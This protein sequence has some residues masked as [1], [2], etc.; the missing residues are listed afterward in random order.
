MTQGLN[1]SENGAAIEYSRK[2][3]PLRVHKTPIPLSRNFVSYDPAIQPFIDYTTSRQFTALEDARNYLNEHLF[4]K[5]FGRS[6]G[7]VMLRPAR[8]GKAFGYYRNASW[9]EDGQAPVPEIS[10]CPYGLNRSPD[11]VFATLVH[12]LC[13][14]YQYEYGKPGRTGYHNLEFAEI[15][16]KVGLFCSSTGEPGGK[17]TGDQ[18]THYI[19]L[20]GLFA[21][22]FTRMPK[23]YL[24]PF[25]PLFDEE[26]FVTGTSCTSVGK[27]KPMNN[28]NK[29]K[30]TCLGCGA[31]AWGKYSLDINCNQCE[32]RMVFIND[33]GK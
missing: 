6:L 4:Q 29:T 12:E 8:H 3:H 13:H 15:M 2:E 22:V 5:V 9:K 31:A 14:Q 32:Q 7:P 18:M 20:D 24:L 21:K 33:F 11:K 10:L 25:K 30:F 19:V 17:Q 1:Q 26:Y 27:P 23:D 28:K 16:R